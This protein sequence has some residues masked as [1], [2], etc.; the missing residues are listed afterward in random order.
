LNPVVGLAV[1]TVLVLAGASA[2]L[3]APPD[4][5]FDPDCNDGNA[6][7][8]DWYDPVLGCRHLAI[9][10]NDG[11]T[12]TTDTCDPGTGCVHT[13]VPDPPNNIPCPGPPGTCG[14][15]GWCIGGQCVGNF[16]GC[17]DGN[18][19]TTDSCF[20]G[21]RCD[22]YFSAPDG[23]LDL[24]LA[25]DKVTLTWRPDRDCLATNYQVAVGPLAGLPVGSNPAG[26][27]CIQASGLSVQDLLVPDPGQGFW[28][29]VR[30][31]RFDTIC[32]CLWRGS[33]GRQR[34][35]GAPGPF[36]DT[37]VCP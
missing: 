20:L 3:A 32:G 13:P 35:A 12:C 37:T 28:Y 19:C 6:C 36:R 7:T 8:D 21:I 26:E 29:V 23:S 14:G 17:D 27:R 4:A 11:N 5:S 16:W 34:I 18:P 2:V 22:Y 10:C 24:W 30:G 15:T 9:S 31:T 1:A 33:Y 25:A